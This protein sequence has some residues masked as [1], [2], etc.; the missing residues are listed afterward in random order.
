MSAAMSVRS[1]VM[2]N[3]NIE[4][5]MDVRIKSGSFCALTWIYYFM[6]KSSIGNASETYL[7]FIVYFFVIGRSVLKI[8]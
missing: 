5:L 7:L 2:C 8:I 1:Y 4:S 6:T 3:W